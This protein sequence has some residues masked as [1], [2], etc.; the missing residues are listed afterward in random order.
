[1]TTEL[2]GKDLEG[3][4]HGLIEVLSRHVIGETEKNHYNPK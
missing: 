1:M 3:S 4:D 2:T